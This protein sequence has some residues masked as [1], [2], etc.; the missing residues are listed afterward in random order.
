MA[1]EKPVPKKIYDPFKAHQIFSLN[2]ISTITGLNKD[3]LY[4]NAKGPSKFI[5]FTTSELE[6]IKS[7]VTEAQKDFFNL[8][9]ISEDKLYNNAKEPLKSTNLT[10]S[11]REKI[12]GV[13]STAQK[14]LSNLLD[15]NII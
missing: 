10:T 15:A 13:V 6:K 8:L 14:D 5:K 4:N 11:E 3:K 2:R 9:G 12:K 1:K 7:V